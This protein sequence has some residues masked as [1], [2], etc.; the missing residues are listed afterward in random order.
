MLAIIINRNAGDTCYQLENSEMM[1]TNVSNYNFLKY[2]RQF[3]AA[4]NPRNADNNNYIYNFWR[5]P[6]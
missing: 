5:A 3:V 2:W 1:A 4:R 6:Q